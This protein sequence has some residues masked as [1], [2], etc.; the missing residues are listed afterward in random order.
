MAPKRGAQLNTLSPNDALSHGPPSPAI[1]R[2]NSPSSIAQL[3]T[4]PAK[5]F[6]R[7]ASA[8]KVNTTTPE[9]RASL[10]SGSGGRKHKISRPTDPRPILDGYQG[11][12]GSR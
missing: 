11:N 6:N 7:S 9:P 8:S 10:S 5:W 2:A 4:R 1:P 12:I 3:F